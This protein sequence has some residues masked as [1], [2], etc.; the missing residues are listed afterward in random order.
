MAPSRVQEQSV[1]EHTL[2]VFPFRMLSH[3]PQ[4]QVATVFMVV[5][6][7]GCGIY[8]CGIMRQNC[9]S[10]HAEKN[11]INENIC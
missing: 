2:H 6:E 5:V 3:L 11:I 4:S 8:S 9:I 1:G 10:S 7:L